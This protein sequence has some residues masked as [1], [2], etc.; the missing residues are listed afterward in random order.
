MIRSNG[1]DHQLTLSDLVWDS[2]VH[3][4]G[5]RLGAHRALEPD[6]SIELR[7]ELRF[8]SA[9]ADMFVE[10][11]PGEAKRRVVARMA[12][13]DAFLG[14]WFMKTRRFAVRGRPIVVFATTQPER[15]LELMKLAD[16]TL[17]LGYAAKGEY[18]AA[19]FAYPSRRHVVFCCL[20]WILGGQALG[21]RLPALPPA[22]RAAGE[23][24]RPETVALLPEDWWPTTGNA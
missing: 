22:A 13:Y 23:S 12:A 1:G 21:L 5:E 19:A 20:D 6:L 24:L 8:S 7:G 14:G 4:H 15:I 11:D 3:V 18:S 10:I 16:E 2:T 9:S 17:T